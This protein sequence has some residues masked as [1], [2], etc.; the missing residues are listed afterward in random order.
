[1]TRSF[2]P[3]GPTYTVEN[4]PI[5]VLRAWYTDLQARHQD[6]HADRHLGWW[7]AHNAAS[8]T[9]TT[10]TGDTITAAGANAMQA[11]REYE[12]QQMRAQRERAA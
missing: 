1:M 9:I 12:D 10:V 5:E 6:G 3:T 7:V 11:I 2:R 8:V 4:A